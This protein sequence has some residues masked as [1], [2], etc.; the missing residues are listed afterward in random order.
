MTGNHPV[1]LP[2]S[3]SIIYSTPRDLVRLTPA[4]E[5]RVWS[6]HLARFDLA[7][8][9]ETRLTSGVTNNVQPALCVR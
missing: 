1:W 4:E 7:L 9:K 6:S 5:H 3:R 8:R 2:D